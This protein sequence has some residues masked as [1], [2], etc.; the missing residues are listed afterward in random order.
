MLWCT[1]EFLG[2]AHKPDFS[3]PMDEDYVEGERGNG[4]VMEGATWSSVPLA[5]S[6]TSS[7][8]PVSCSTH[9]YSI[10]SSS[11]C[12]RGKESH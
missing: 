12:I 8:L 1:S 5:T 4:K 6:T 2:N 11:S 9:L 10:C 7:F 3:V